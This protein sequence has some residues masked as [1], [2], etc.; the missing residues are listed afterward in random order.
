MNDRLTEN[1]RVVNP[2]APGTLWAGSVDPAGLA[3]A[4]ALPGPAEGRGVRPEGTAAPPSTLNAP[5]V[6]PQRQ[7]ESDRAFE[8]FRVYLEL[9]PRRRYAA[10]GRSVGASLRT[11]KRWAS[12]FDWRGR[13]QLHA[14]RGVAQYTATENALG[15]EAVLDAVARAQAFSDRQEAVAE[16]LLDIA[17]RFLERAGDDDLDQMSFADVCK[18]VEVAS[19]L[20]PQ[21]QTREQA[22]AAPA[23]GLGEQITALLDQVC[24][25]ASAPSQS[26]KE[27]AA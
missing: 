22:A 19:R 12:D 21:A 18:A 16:G 1:N 11:I 9:G 2:P 20:K 24:R 4:P 23:R 7:G 10:V 25:E 15:R 26:N 17:E 13:I 8:A 5:P 6:F 3:P 27:K 14:A